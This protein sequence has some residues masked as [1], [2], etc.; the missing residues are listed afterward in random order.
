[1]INH[2]ES[3][4]KAL[5]HIIDNLDREK[6]S[7]LL[8]EMVETVNRGNKIITTAL[9]KNVPICEKFT[10]TL[11]SLGINAYFLHTNS[12]VHGDLGVVKRGDLV[13]ILTKSGSTEESVYLY[14]HLLVKKANV[15]LMTY[16]PEGEL[17][18]RAEKKIVL[19]LD[20][21][22]DKWNL[23]PNNSSI[24][25]LFILQA[26][27]MEL[28]ERLNVSLEEFKENHPGGYIG[29]VARGELK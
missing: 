26:L 4:L 28:A 5:R 17:T 19:H 22:G 3:Q 14:D 9:G 21:E 15:W 13:L 1:M 10:G 8:D 29:K 25:Y 23:V 16:N 2:L 12:A 18:K 24:G 11:L 7:V 20:H 6:L 27:A